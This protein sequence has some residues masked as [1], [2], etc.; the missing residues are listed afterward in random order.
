V[1]GA[2]AFLE[3]GDKRCKPS[4]EPNHDPVVAG[5]VH[6]GQDGGELFGGQGKGLLHEDGEATLQGPADEAGM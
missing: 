4:V 5:L 3:L 1:G 6:S 2:E